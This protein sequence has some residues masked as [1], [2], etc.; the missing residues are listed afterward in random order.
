MIHFT[1][2]PYMS[3]FGFLIVALL[4]SFDAVLL[5][6]NAG[7]AAELPDRKRTDSKSV[8]AGDVETIRQI[9]VR[10]QQLSAEGKYED[11]VGLEFV[12][13]LPLEAGRARGSE[14]AIGNFSCRPAWLW[15]HH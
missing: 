14:L 7:Y 11:A 13:T 9:S 4:S 12:I 5:W 1:R 6:E 8:K 15:I 3:I 2:P 10:V